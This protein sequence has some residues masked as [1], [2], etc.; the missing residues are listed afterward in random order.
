MQ[1]FMRRSQQVFQLSRSVF[2]PWILGKKIAGMA[3]DI[4]ID[5]RNTCNER[6]RIWRSNWPPIQNSDLRISVASVQGN[7]VGRNKVCWFSRMDLSYA[8]GLLSYD[9]VKPL[10]R[11][12]HLAS[13]RYDV[14]PIMAVLPPSVPSRAL[15]SVCS[16]CILLVTVSGRQVAQ[17]TFCLGRTYPSPASCI[18]LL[19]L[20]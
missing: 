2:L 19:S 11:S 13:Y 15:E 10:L 1:R 16:S 20:R 5:S 8:H 4:V 7:R 18:S 17:L 6:A 3:R 9:P 14:R 12:M